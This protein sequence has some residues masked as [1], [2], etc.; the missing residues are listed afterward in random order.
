MHSVDIAVDQPEALGQEAEQSCA[1]QFKA[2]GSE[3]F[4]IWI[5]NLLLTIITFG[6]YSAWA[7]VRRN[8][9]FYSSTEV[10]GSS[11]EYHGNP[12]AILKGRVIA[13]LL[14]GAYNVTVKYAPI[15]GLFMGLL[16]WAVL[17]WLIWKSMQF[18]LYNTSYRGIRFGFDGSAG[19]AYLYWLVFP[20]L[21]GL[22][23]GLLGPL[24]H[25]RL[26]RFQHSESRFGTTKFS[27]DGSVGSFYLAYLILIGI[28]VGGI[29]VFAVALAVLGGVSILT[30]G[31]ATPFVMFIGIL[32]GYAF[33]FTVFPIFFSMIQNL[34]WNHTQ[35]GEHRFVSEL[36]WPRM[37]FIML[38]NLLGVVCTLGL[39]IPFAHV[40]MMR[41]RLESTSLIVKGSMDGFVADTQK[42]ITAAGEGM[43]D[44]MDFDMS[45]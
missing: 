20:L 3:Y 26:K 9:Y 15:A 4:G 2:T 22:T 39:F 6:I 13:F 27:F 24:A 43:V 35:L 12:I 14:F 10:A 7:K 1:I 44:L 36:R 40:R 37:T 45:I 29:I 17:P 18:K 21:S 34:I 30:G 5:V 19:K 38:T 11:F 32:G 42:N 8:K 41:Y 25:Q 16:L 28:I 33:L 31:A 23:L